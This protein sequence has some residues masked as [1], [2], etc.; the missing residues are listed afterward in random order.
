[1][2]TMFIDTLPSPFYDKVI[3]NVSSNFSDL[4]VIG[5]RIEAGIRRGKFTYAA[6]KTG[7]VKKPPAFE[8]N[9]EEANA[10]RFDSFF[11][12]GKSTQA[13]PPYPTQIQ[14][15]PQRS[16][17]AHAFSPPPLPQPY[18]PS[19]LPPY[20]PPY[21]PKPSQPIVASSKNDPNVSNDPLVLQGSSYMNVVSDDSS[22]QDVRIED[23]AKNK[24]VIFAKMLKLRIIK[25]KT[26]EAGRCGFHSASTHSLEEYAEFEG[27]LRQMIS[28]HQ[29][30]MRKT[31]TINGMAIIQKEGEKTPKLLTIHN[32]PAR[33]TRKLLV[34]QV[35]APFMYKN[36]KAVPWEYDKAFYRGGL[37]NK[38]RANYSIA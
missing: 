2:V 13:S 34:I 23:L 11:G 18:L 16:P 26:I 4:V 14:L 21:Q 17:I 38:T 27:L 9:K 15:Y 6:N 8:K 36:S 12:H 24:A 5:E 3:G 10:I 28:S 1:M 20:Q 29:I 30:L 31:M 35:L 33:Q 37:S 19:C 7:F 32:N 25:G 22:L